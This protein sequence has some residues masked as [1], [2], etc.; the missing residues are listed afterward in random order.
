MATVFQIA[1]NNKGIVFT[2]CIHGQGS[3]HRWQPDESYTAIILDRRANLPAD[4]ERASV[5][6]E[7]VGRLNVE[8]MDP[9][10]SS[11]IT[12]IWLLFRV[13]DDID[14]E[15]KWTMLGWMAF[16]AETTEYNGYCQAKT[17]VREIQSRWCT[18]R[19]FGST[20]DLL[21]SL[22]AENS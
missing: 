12:A 8:S 2:G 1:Y 3:S 6:A 21:R 14:L 16:D 11:G 18:A 13:P 5:F 9:N 22:H 17:F 20:Q 19:K 7:L 10:G 15:T 4:T